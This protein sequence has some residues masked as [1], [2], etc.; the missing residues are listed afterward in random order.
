MARP[1]IWKREREGALARFGK[2]EGGNERGIDGEYGGKQVEQVVTR[3]AQG[4]HIL[5]KRNKIKV[6]CEWW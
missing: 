4:S 5:K 2:K 1:C 6:G 3:V